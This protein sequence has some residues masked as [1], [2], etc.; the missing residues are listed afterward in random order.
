MN[1]GE[2]EIEENKHTKLRKNYSAYILYILLRTIL[3]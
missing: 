3:C 1:K 2:M